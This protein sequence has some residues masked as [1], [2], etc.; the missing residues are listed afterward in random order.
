[1]FTTR[2]SNQLPRL[3]KD[4]G[5]EENLPLIRIWHVAKAFMEAIALP[6]NNVLGMVTKTSGLNNSVL[7]KRITTKT[8]TI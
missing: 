5:C 8:I 4:G 2:W 7:I 3:E 6:L 1:M